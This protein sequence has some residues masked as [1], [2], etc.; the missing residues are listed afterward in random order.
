MLTSRSE[1]QQAGADNVCMMVSFRETE[2]LAKEW[3]ACSATASAEGGISRDSASTGSSAAYRFS[4]ASAV[5]DRRL[6]RGAQGSKPR[7]GARHG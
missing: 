2:L 6:R 3:N 1:T 7:S 4:E 5:Y